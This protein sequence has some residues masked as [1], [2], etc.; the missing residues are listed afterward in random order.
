VQEFL[1]NDVLLGT[2]CLVIRT[3]LDSLLEESQPSKEALKEYG[4]IFNE[5]CNEKSIKTALHEAAAEGNASTIGY[6]LDSLKLRECSNTLMKMLLTEDALGHTDLHITA[7]YNSVQALK[8]IY[9]LAEA[10]TPYLTHS[11]LVNTRDQ[12]E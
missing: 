9:E 10:V 6:L 3:F 1:L 12:V 11:L 8:K 4:E 2:D 7:E 5:Q